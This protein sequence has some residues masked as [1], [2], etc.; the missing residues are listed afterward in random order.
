MK[1][2]TNFKTFTAD[3]GNTVTVDTSANLNFT[4]KQEVNFFDHL[5]NIA[6]DAFKNMLKAFGVTIEELDDYTPIKE[7]V[8]L[9]ISVAESYGANIPYVDENY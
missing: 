9:V 3:D 5:D 8:E 6:I 2:E 4:K 7:M 1:I